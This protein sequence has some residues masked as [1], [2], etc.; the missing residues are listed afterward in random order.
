MGAGRGWANGRVG[1]VGGGGRWVVE[2][3]VYHTLKQKSSH[4]V[5]I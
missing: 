1:L 3:M 4:C 5:L 2:G